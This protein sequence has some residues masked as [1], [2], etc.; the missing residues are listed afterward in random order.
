MLA[1]YL[2]PKTC[3]QMESTILSNLLPVPVQ[4][5]VETEHEEPVHQCFI[6]GNTVA[7]SYNEIKQHHT[8]PVF[9]KDNEPVISHTDF[10]DAAFDV[11]SYV[12]GDGNVSTP[13]VRLSHPIKGRV[14]EAKYKSASE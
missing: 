5:A 13:Q 9:V 8:I 1:N 3:L 6:K 14:P 12:Y 7:V 2:T 4:Q 10:I 11:C